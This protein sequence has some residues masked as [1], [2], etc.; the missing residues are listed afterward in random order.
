MFQVL[1]R[2]VRNLIEIGR[3]HGQMGNGLQCLLNAVELFPVLCPDDV[4]FRILL[5][6]LYLHLNVNLHDVSL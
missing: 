1:E 3:Q 4:E 2:M 6:R 5:A